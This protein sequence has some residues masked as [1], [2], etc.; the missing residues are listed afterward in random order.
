MPLTPAV[1]RLENAEVEKAAELMGRAFQNDPLLIH[2]LPEPEERAIL[3]RRHFEPVVR[4]AQQSGEVR[5]IRGEDGALWAVACWRLPGRHEPTRAE[6]ERSGL[7]RMAELIGAGPTERLDGV[8]AFLG[9]RREACG[10]ADDHWHLALI[11]TAP[12]AQGQGL[13]R[14]LLAAKLAESDPAGQPVFFETTAAVNVPFY[15]RNG[16]DVLEEGVDP[17]SGVPYWLFLRDPRRERS[18]GRA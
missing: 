8:F 7:T 14:A 12:E 1:E 13:G 18:P 5:C 3:G 15:T 9:E 4:Q 16:F 10:V 2:A 11:G 17:T 6:A